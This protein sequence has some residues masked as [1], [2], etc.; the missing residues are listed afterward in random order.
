MQRPAGWDA[1]TLVE[2]RYV[3]ASDLHQLGIML[4]DYNSRVTSPQGRE[5]LSLLARPAQAL[6]AGAVTAGS[7]LEHLWLQC[8]GA[9]CTEAGAQP[10]ETGE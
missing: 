8:P 10:G 7:L 6:Q 4:Q 5:F 2:G 1:D 9:R 3:A